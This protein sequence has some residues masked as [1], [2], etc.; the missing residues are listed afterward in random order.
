VQRDDRLESD[1]R[2]PELLWAA[3]RRDFPFQRARRGSVI[4]RLC[5]R[6]G[7][8]VVEV[9]QARRPPSGAITGSRARTPKMSDALSRGDLD[10]I[11]GFTPF[12]DAD[13][14]L[15]SHKN[16]P[17]APGPRPPPN[18]QVPSVASVGPVGCT[19]AR[20]PIAAAPTSSRATRSD[21][22]QPQA[23]RRGCRRG[24]AMCWKG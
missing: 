15:G 20:L 19:P 13:E 17:G 14:K 24:A 10:G 11:Q 7:P 9:H 22:S 2:G 4:V 8:V 18:C 12:V 21:L 3:S 1:A 6:E 5:G 23:A 16:V